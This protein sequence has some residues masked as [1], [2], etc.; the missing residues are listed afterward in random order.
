[1]LTSCAALFVLGVTQ[2]ILN[3]IG[4]SPEFFLARDAPTTDIVGLALILG[5]IVPVVVGGLVLVV[6]QFSERAGRVAYFVVVSVLGALLVLPLIERWVS[7]VSGWAQIAIAGILGG[8]L[9]YAVQRWRPVQSALSLAG[10]AVVVV[11]LTFLFLTPTSELILDSGGSVDM[12]AARIGSPAP[13]VVLIFDELPLASLVDEQGNIQADLYPGFARLSEDATWF[14]NAV[15]VQRLTQ[16][17]IPAMLSGVN[18]EPEFIPTTV[19][20]PHNLF[21]LLG[22]TYEMHAM[23]SLTGLCPADACEEADVVRVTDSQR[24]KTTVDD[25]AVVAGHVLLPASFTGNLPSIDENWAGF[26][27]QAAEAAQVARLSTNEELRDI[28]RAQV[29]AGRGATIEQFIESIDAPS[30]RPT[31]HFAH[32]L[33]PH[34]PWDHLPSGQR[35]LPPAPLPGTEGQTWTDDEWLVNQGYQL[36]LVQTMYVDHVVDTLVE[37][38]EQIGTYDEA[39]VVVASDHGIVFTPGVE[40]RRMATPESIGGLAAVP[41]FIK[42]PGL[43]GGFVDDYRAETIDLLPTIAD[44]LD[45]ELS[46]EVDGASLIAAERP[47]RRQSVITGG[48]TVTFGTDGHEMFEVAREKVA[49]FGDEGPFALAPEGT[50][51]LLGLDLDDLDVRQ[52]TSEVASVT[53]LQSFAGVDTDDAFLPALVQGNLSPASDGESI[54]VVGMNGVVGAVTRTYVDEEGLTQFYALVPPAYLIDGDNEVKILVLDESA[55]RPTFL[56]V[57]P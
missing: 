56:D 9:G 31:L 29:A 43:N 32:V 20:Y 26:A 52:T 41:M 13:V 39:V 22:N 38:L 44:A 30:D 14:R 17:S 12:A 51:E 1:M 48:G 6:R 34:A 18:P 10:I 45:A 47:A 16:F 21:T 19:D 27:A 42:A 46:W 24:W 50:Q 8:I 49:I 25:L 28:M 40:N 4:D 15:T 57:G 23:E 53:E 36:H 33:L 55:A 7:D 3:L 35:Y 11:P 2:P 54:V 5:L 37:R